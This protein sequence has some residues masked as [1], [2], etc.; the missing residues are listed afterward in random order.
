MSTFQEMTEAVI[1]GNAKKAKEYAEKALAEGASPQVIINEG[2][3]AGM[4][5]L[6]LNSRITKYTFRRF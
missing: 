4:K 3:I 5:W 2:L 1:T 6:G